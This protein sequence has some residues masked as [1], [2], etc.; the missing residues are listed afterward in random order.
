MNCTVSEIDK[1][2]VLKLT[3]TIDWEKARILDNT[4]KELIDKG[5][6]QIVIDLNEVFFMCSGSLGALAYNY[7]IVNR[8]NGNIY[9]IF[10]TKY[11]KYLFETISFDIVFK[12]YIYESIENFEKSVIY[13]R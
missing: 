9:L 10:S 13:K 11:I 1:Y 5:F 12:G 6:I 8:A 7:S 4:L 2:K 3:G